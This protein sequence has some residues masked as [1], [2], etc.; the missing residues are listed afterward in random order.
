MIR[1]L[2]ARYKLQRMVNRNKRS[3]ATIEFA[4][5]REAAKLGLSRKLA[6]Q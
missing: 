1:R 6:R 2:I 5:R 4:R 3:P